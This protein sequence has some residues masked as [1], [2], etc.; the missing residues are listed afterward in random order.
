MSL[1]TDLLLDRRRLKRRLVFWRVFAVVALVVA[2]L[3]GLRG[4]G[5]R[6]E[7]AHITRVTVNGI[8]TEDR[9][10][11]ES[12]D[13]LATDDHVKAVILSACFFYWVQ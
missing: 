5:L 1:E 2:V 12:I 10:L 11:T 6:P 8:I 13:K 3:V 7:G 9:K 4:A